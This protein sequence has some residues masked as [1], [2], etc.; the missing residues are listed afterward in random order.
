[1]GSRLLTRWLDWAAI[2]VAL[3]A[4]VAL[5]VTV[6]VARTELASL[7]EAMVR[8]EG[9]SLTARLHE[10]GQA[11][12]HGPPTP[13]Q[14]A[15]QLEDLGASGLR[16]V[17]LEAP[18]GS[19]TAGTSRIP[20]DGLRPG[21]VVVQEGRA[22]LVSAMPG[23]P[24]PPDGLRGAPP[25]APRQDAAMVIEFETLV[26]ARVSTAIDR[27]SAVGFGAVIV[28]LVCAGALTARALERTGL[29]R[30]AE[31]ERR[32][33]ALGQMAGVMA[34]ELR[35]PLASLKGNA[36]LLAEMLASGTREHGK[37]ELVV[38]E[39]IRLERLTQDLLA[40]VRDGALA[41]QEIDKAELLER[42][43]VNTPRARVVIEDE[44]PRGAL[45]VDPAR[46]SA[47]IGNLVQNALQATSGEETVRV[48]L[49]ADGATG[50]DVTIEV[51]DEGP[52][53]RAGEEER[54]FEPFFTTRIHGTGL[55]LVVARRAVQDHGGTL[56]AVASERGGLF[57]ISLPGVS[58]S[59]RPPEG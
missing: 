35:N 3:I 23:P 12:H 49:S 44:S 42:A 54:I 32:L 59:R 36:Q 47:A 8:G 11:A 51:R 43:L 40:F 24:P 22:L 19:I 53:V 16:F 39:A 7:S 46:L 50:G 45:Y 20:H 10:E 27:T 29:E 18:F 6:L 15:G 21:T 17:S 48:R 30:K 31:K 9:N 57:R 5:G 58:R 4:A 2:A 1:M 14:L 41:P 55:G 37:A 38:T 56:V 33:S 26:T 52:G 13:A 25:G 28:L 34:H